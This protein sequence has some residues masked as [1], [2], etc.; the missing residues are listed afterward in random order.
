MKNIAERQETKI[1]WHFVILTQAT[2]RLSWDH[3]YYVSCYKAGWRK[4]GAGAK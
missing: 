2:V 3:A 4:T 1:K